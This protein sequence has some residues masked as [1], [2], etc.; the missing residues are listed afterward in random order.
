M[1][2]K[3]LKCNNLQIVTYIAFR[4]LLIFCDLRNL[5]DKKILYAVS[6]IEF[7]TP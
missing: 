1:E 5:T 2:R 7:V 4:M 6:I 3:H